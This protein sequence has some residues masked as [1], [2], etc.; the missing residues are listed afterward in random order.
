ML[1]GY[2]PE[3]KKIEETIQQIYRNFALKYSE[4]QN[5]ELSENEKQEQ[6]NELVDNRMNTIL[7][8]TNT[9]SLDKISVEDK[10][11]L[12]IEENDK[13]EVDPNVV[14]TLV[15]IY[16][17]RA[18]MPLD[19]G[20]GILDGITIKDGEEL[21]D[22]DTSAFEEELRQ[23]FTEHYYDLLCDGYNVFLSNITV[24]AD[25]DG[26]INN[27]N[28]ELIE[29]AIKHGLNPEKFKFFGHDLIVQDGLVAEEDILNE[30]N[31]FYATPE[32]LNQRIF[33][34]YSKSL[35][36]Q[37]YNEGKSF[38]FDDDKKLKNA[39]ITYAEKN[40]IPIQNTDVLE[41]L[42][43]N[44]DKVRGIA[45]YINRVLNENQIITDDLTDELIAEIEKDYSKIMNLKYFDFRNLE[46]VKKVL[47]DQYVSFSLT[48]NEDSILKI[49][50][51]YPD[52]VYATPE[53]IKNEYKKVMDEVERISHIDVFK[54]GRFDVEKI[55]KKKEVLRRYITEHG[56][57]GID[58]SIPDVEVDYKKIEMIADNILSEYGEKCKDKE[59]MKVRLLKKIEDRYPELVNERQ[60]IWLEDLVG[61]ELKEMGNKFVSENLYIQKDFVYIGDYDGF[62]SKC[63]Y[64]TPEVL[65]DKIAALDEKISTRDFCTDE[66]RIREELV[67]Y[68]KDNKFKLQISDIESIEQRRRQEKDLFS[69]RGSE[70]GLVDRDMLQDD[71]TARPKIELEDS[72]L[73]VI[74]KVSEGNP[75]AAVAIAKLLQSNEYGYMLLLDLDDMNIRGS[76]IW[77]AYK[78]LYNEDGEKFANAVQKRDSKIVDFINQELAFVGGEKAVTGGASFDRNKLP[79]KYRFTQEEVEQLKIDREERIKKQQ[80]AREKM[81]ANSPAK[82]VK[83]DKKRRDE[84][85]AK[86][87]AYRQRLIASGKKSIGELDAELIDLQSKEQQAKELYEQYDKQLPNKSN[88]EL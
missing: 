71:P 41:E 40:G 3:Q 62:Y 81:L 26:I 39:Y 65:A 60:V 63:L 9:K 55:N 35:F 32:A 52:I 19:N 53:F 29:M 50:E 80:E 6:I 36:K 61:E 4:I 13:I 2:D 59:G 21:E 44:I 45:N 11:A 64:A 87:Q 54:D 20:M 58:I 78:Y 28:G 31:V 42:P 51:F 25:K 23:Y 5:S 14:D 43:V 18:K 46:T 66:K 8:L 57:E 27:K 49:D 10:K 22:I 38:L 73:D 74:S 70:I 30:I 79:G 37:K 72:I 7:V 56:I 33:D 88:K 48:I 77:E 1:F 83:P 17:R 67:R 85:E 82:K 24:A 47:E 12:G 86:R 69:F 84:R 16:A 15:S 75:G 34:L 68:A 76:Q